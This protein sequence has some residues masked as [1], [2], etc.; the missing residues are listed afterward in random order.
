MLKQLLYPHFFTEKE[1][2]ISETGAFVISLFRYDSNVCA[3]RVKNNRGEIIVLPYQ[4]QQIWH[5]TFDGRPLHMKS[6]FDE[7]IKTQ[8]YFDSYGGFFLHCGVTAVGVPGPDDSHP[9][10]GELPNA[11]YQDAYIFHGH[12]KAG[13]YVII[14]GTY[15]HKV[16][17]NH[18][19]KADSTIKLYEDSAMMDVTMKITN[20]LHRPMEVM[21]L[22]HINFRPVDYAKLEYSAPYDPKHVVANVGIPAHIKTGADTKKLLSFLQKLKQDP[23]LHHTINPLDPYDPEV[24]MTIKYQAD[25]EGIAHSLQI[26]PDGYAHYVNHRI[27]QMDN[28][29][30][31]IARTPD[32]DAM[33]LVLPLNTGSGGYQKESKSGNIKT[34]APQAEMYFDMQIGLL[35]PNLVDAVR[36]KIAKSVTQPQP[37]H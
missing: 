17:L 22:G 31:W 2:T 7:P 16:A 29:L 3:I 35:E 34:L 13:R 37:R 1:R 15:T 32:H 33:G 8:N 14:G 28:A 4:G 21:Y 27:D 26:H 12:D 19:Y 18:H 10:H 6:I 5:A 24:V 25:E 11:V 20:L 9:L 36:Q 30:R 23:T